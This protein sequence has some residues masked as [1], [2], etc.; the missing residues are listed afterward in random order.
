MSETMTDTDTGTRTPTPPPTGSD[1]SSPVSLKDQLAA[2]EAKSQ[3]QAVE[4]VDATLTEIRKVL[5]DQDAALAEYTPEII[6]ELT[7]AQDVL[8]H[9][10]GHLKTLLEGELG[11]A[12]G[13]VNQKINE[14]NVALTNARAALDAQLATPLYRATKALADAEKA[15][16]EAAE[17]LAK[18]RKPVA[19]IK[20]RHKAASDLVKEITN[21]AT[22]ETHKHGEAYWKLGL[23]GTNPVEGQP[24]LK[25]L[26]DGPPAVVSA[27]D[28]P[29][30]IRMAWDA[31]QVKR[32]AA[33]QAAQALSTAQE[34]LKQAESAVADHEK[35]QIPNIAE[36]LGA[37][38][39][40]K[41]S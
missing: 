14:S 40:H 15:R 21:L 27:A 30:R 19:G 31:F 10:F 8:A 3:Q 23:A 6:A 39:D 11:D 41:A 20:A 12:K 37:W 2:L 38:E 26:V 9:K 13:W 5:D 29:G 25:A 7:E 35:N 1:S 4:Q 22:P 18:W 28:L 24:Y 17:T 33:E 34:T 32:V 36:T 16:D